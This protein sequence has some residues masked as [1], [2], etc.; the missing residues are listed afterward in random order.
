MCDKGSTDSATSVGPIGKP[1]AIDMHIRHEVV[2]RQHHAFR[3]TGGSGRVDDRREIVRSDGLQVR[4]ECAGPLLSKRFAFLLQLVQRKT[5][6]DVFRHFRLE[7]DEVLEWRD[8]RE[9]AARV[10]R[11]GEWK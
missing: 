5:A 7:E 4:I 10:C 2:V 6:L 3:L 9:L 11:A 8:W 1:F